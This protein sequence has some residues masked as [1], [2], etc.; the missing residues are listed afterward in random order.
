[1]ART[2]QLIVST[3]YGESIYVWEWII[4]KAGGGGLSSNE[5]EASIYQKAAGDVLSRG[6]HPVLDIYGIFESWAVLLGVCSFVCL[7]AFPCMRR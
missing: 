1:M 5:V 4:W 7:L 3:P 2:G 6:W